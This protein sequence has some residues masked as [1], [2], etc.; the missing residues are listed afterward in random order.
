MSQL[1]N[2]SNKNSLPR[3]II[4]DFNEIKINEIKIKYHKLDRLDKIIVKEMEIINNKIFFKKI[5]FNNQIKD[6]NSENI[7]L[8]NYILAGEVKPSNTKIILNRDGK[9]KSF[10]VYDGF[11]FKYKPNDKRISET[12]TNAK[13]ILTI[14]DK[15]RHRESSTQRDILKS[16]II[17]TYKQISGFE[18]ITS[19]DIYTIKR[20]ID[21]KNE[22]MFY[23]TFIDD[24]FFPITGKNKQDKK[25]NFYNYKIKENAKKFISLINYRINDDFKNKNGI[26][27]D[28]LSNKE[29]I[30]IND[31]IHIQT[32]LKDVRHAIA[33]FNFDFIQKLFDNEQAFN[34]KFDGIEILNILFNQKQEK[35][36]EAQTNYI[37]EETIK[38]LD[39]KELSF[40]KLHS[41]YSQICQK[42]PAFNKLINSFIIQ[43]GIE[44]KELK[45]Y[46]SQK[47]N[48]KFDYYLDIHTCKIY[49]DIYN[50]HKKFVADKQ[51]LE[52]QK[53]DGQKIKKLND[54]INQLKTKMNNLTK[55]NSLKRLEIKFR[56]AFG[57]I[58]TEYQT[59]K[60]FNER[61]I[62]DIKANKYSTKIE[63]LD[64]GKIK[65]YISITH[66]EKRF[67][68]YK[69]FNKKTNKNI[70]KTIFQS[71]EKE[72]FENLVKNDN[73]IKMMFLFQLLLPRELKGEFLG[74]ILKIYHDLKNIDNDTKPDEKSLSELNISTALKL[75]ILVKN[76]RQIN[77]FNYTISNNTKYEEKEKRFYE[78]GNQWKDIYKKLYISHDFDIFDIHL[79]IPIIKYNINLYKLIGDFEVY[80]LLKY[81]ERNTNYK[82]LDKLI[83]AE[84]LKYKGYYNFTTLLSKAINIALNDKEYHNI[85][86]LRNNTSHQDIQNIISSFKNNKLLEQRE[87]IIELISKESLK[88]KLHFDPI[89]DFTMKTLQL[90]KSLEVH[91][92]KSEKIENLLKKEPLLPN[93]VYLLYKLKGIEFIKKELISNIG[94]TKYEEKIQEKIA[95]GVEK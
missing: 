18:N 5:L 66:E 84:E 88:K 67:F 47:Y 4:S 65:E 50:Q 31:F 42:K 51:F 40:K 72:T 94:I 93:D 28:Y 23:Y 69:T 62:E 75:K 64:Y 41:F 16:S 49:K 95:K 21:F 19:K 68:N 39:E 33:H 73:L 78:E 63:L 82:T 12:K 7:E 13:Y 15:T 58:F 57:F 46:I 26:L 77:L 60:N 87:N 36:F 43:D 20:Y 11:T 6:I 71:L 10:I 34:S 44:N 81:L 89:N 79:I 54:Q 45:D 30:I 38:I 56:L 17:E 76:I 37:E 1:K 24:F 32:I 59:F 53:T 55:K 80:L 35:Y 2:P 48:S 91:S 85:T 61:F 70:N 92:D 29:E 8:E 25:N 27:Y 90:L 14:K 83:E 3:I 86:H 52:N 9:E 74:F 22:M